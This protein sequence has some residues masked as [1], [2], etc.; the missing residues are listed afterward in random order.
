MHDQ[1][2]DATGDAPDA[3]D[4]SVPSCPARGPSGAP[5]EAAAPLLRVPLPSVEDLATVAEARA[6]I[7]GLDAALAVLL[8][9]RAAV[10]ALVQR[11]KPVGGFAGRDPDRERAIVDA[12]AEHAPSLGRDRLAKIMSAVIEAGLAAADR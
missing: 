7:D 8:E 9:R 6:A 10:A 1:V 4:A 11:L 12:M 2:I 5:A 3:P